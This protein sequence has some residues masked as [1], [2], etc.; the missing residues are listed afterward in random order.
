MVS[1]RNAGRR[2]TGAG[3]GDSGALGVGVGDAGLGDV[4]VGD[5]GLEGV[6]DEGTGLPVASSASSSTVRS[7]AVLGAVLTASSTAEQAVSP[8]VLPLLDGRRN[9]TKK[10]MC[11]ARVSAT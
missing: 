10:S 5:A 6:V 11:D 2:T 9:P 7:S 3:R 1:V 8:E 4:G